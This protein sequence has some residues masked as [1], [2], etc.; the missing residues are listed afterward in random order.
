MLAKK[1]YPRKNS[2]NTRSSFDRLIPKPASTFDVTRPPDL[3]RSRSSRS[4]FAVL[5]CQPMAPGFR[6]RTEHDSNE[7]WNTAGW[8]AF[9]PKHGIM[10]P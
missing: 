10:A 5:F 9:Q 8:F 6:V 4:S 1:S 2:D 7:K 3:P